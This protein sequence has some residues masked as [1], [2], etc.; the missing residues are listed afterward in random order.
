MKTRRLWN[1]VCNL[2]W[3]QA[4][5]GKSGAVIW[6]MLAERSRNSIA[7]QWDFRYAFM[8]GIWEMQLSWKL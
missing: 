4:L 1:A 7:L 3:G 6:L 2:F 5:P 8:A